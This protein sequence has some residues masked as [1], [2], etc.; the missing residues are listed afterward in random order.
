MRW[1]DATWMQLP[2]KKN[3]YSQKRL[4]YRLVMTQKTHTRPRD[5]RLKGQT[6]PD[7]ALIPPSPHTHTF[8]TPI[9]PKYVVSHTPAPGRQAHCPLPL[10][11][12]AGLEEK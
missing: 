12:F 5:D 4:L 1:P 11:L 9:S 8:A 6:F 3:D 10:P 2:P 7:S